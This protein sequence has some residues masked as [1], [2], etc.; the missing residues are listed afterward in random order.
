MFFCSPLD[1]PPF[2]EMMQGSRILIPPPSISR[3]GGKKSAHLYEKE[4]KKGDKGEKKRKKGKNKGK[5]LV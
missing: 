5:K 3:G 1:Q 4:G 2:F